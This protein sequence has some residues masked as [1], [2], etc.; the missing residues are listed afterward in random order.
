MKELHIYN[1]E[2]IEIELLGV[3]SEQAGD[4]NKA[5]SLYKK[6]I[7]IC[8]TFT[9]LYN[10]GRVLNALEEYHKSSEYL[11]KSIKISPHPETYLELGNSY[12]SLNE[13]DKAI[14]AWKSS[15]DLEPEY[16]K[17]LRCLWV[18]HIETGDD[19]IAL[20]YAKEASRLGLEEAEI[21]LSQRLYQ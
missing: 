10:C 9:N 20:E 21:W 8:E 14:N 6:S 5:L 19:A 11:L 3:K 2:A 18:I 7:D 13:I 17:G 16:L 12:Y 15:V 4:I 1:P